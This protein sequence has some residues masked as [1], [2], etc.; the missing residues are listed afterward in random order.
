MI[1]KLYAYENVLIPTF[2]RDFLYCFGVGQNLYFLSSNL[3]SCLLIGG[4][5]MCLKTMTCLSVIYMFK[6][7]SEIL[8]R[9][10][11]H[12]QQ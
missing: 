6:A 5:Q 9:I 8:E 7:C 1:S 4:L 2:K 3:N 11:P 10:H 12:C